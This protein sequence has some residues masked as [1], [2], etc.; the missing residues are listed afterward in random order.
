MDSLTQEQQRLPLWRLFFV[1]AGVMT[2]IFWNSVL[3]LTLY[4]DQ[5]IEAGFFVYITFAF[6]FGNIASFFTSRI[7]FKKFSSKKQIFFFIC[8]SCVSFTLLGILLET[9]EDTLTKKIVAIILIAINGYGTGCFQG[10][11]SG[12]SS[13]CGPI[14]ISYMNVGTGVSGFG[15]NILAII[16]SLLFPVSH[17]GDTVAMRKQLF[18]YLVGMNV[19]F[20]FFIIVLYKYMKR[21]GHFIDDIDSEA[22]LT[23]QLADSETNIDSDTLLNPDASNNSL[24]DPTKSNLESK[25]RRSFT[26]WKTHGSEPTFSFFSSMKRII[27]IWSGIIFTYYFTLEVVCFLVPELTKIYDNNSNSYLLAYF[28]LYNL[29]DTLGKLVPVRFNFKSS[30]TL[31]L[32]NLLRVFF[33]VYFIFVLYSDNVPAFFTHYAFRGALYL[34]LGITNGYITNNFFCHSAERFRNPKNKDKAGFFVIFGLVLGV[35]LGSFSGILWNF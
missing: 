28:F 34:L 29:G 25:T 32:C 16:F 19:L 8:L 11:L 26:T 17:E 15:S 31:H 23:E 10:K 21:Y 18:S 4:F 33:Q 5:T 14:S 7:F 24:K 20:V 2:L 6:S 35:T 12:F 13:S 27:D 3:N 30:F 9:I 1:F 22:N